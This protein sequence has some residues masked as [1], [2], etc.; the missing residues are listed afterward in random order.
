MGRKK[1]GVLLA[2]LACKAQLRLHHKRGVGRLQARGHGLPVRQGQH[3]TEV[4]HGHQG[5]TYAA[6][7]F[8]FERLAQMQRYLVTE[9]VKIYPGGCATPFSTTQHTTIE[10][11]G[12]VEISDIEGE[13]EQ[14]FHGVSLS[15]AAGF[16]CATK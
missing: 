6:R 3:Q 8:G 2:W 1:H 10:L 5:V 11:T 16:I 14:A 7:A 15:G 12:S 13:V 4:R 9:K